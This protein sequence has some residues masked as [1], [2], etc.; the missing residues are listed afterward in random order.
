MF[1][2]FFKYINFWKEKAGVLG[3]RHEWIRYSML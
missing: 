2:F 3:S 1:Q